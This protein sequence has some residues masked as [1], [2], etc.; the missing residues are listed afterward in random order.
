MWVSYRLL[1]KPKVKVGLEHET[2]RVDLLELTG[3]VPSKEAV[4][5]QQSRSGDHLEK[6]KGEASEWQ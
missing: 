1:L 4:H 3:E 2:E 6:L 5:G